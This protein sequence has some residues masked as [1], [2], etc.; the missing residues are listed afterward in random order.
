MISLSLMLSGLLS[1]LSLI[2]TGEAQLLMQGSIS[3]PSSSFCT[4]FL[5]ASKYL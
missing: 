1:F 3:P 4:S 5:T 2:S